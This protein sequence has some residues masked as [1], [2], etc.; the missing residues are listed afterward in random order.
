MILKFP[1]QC[2]SIFNNQK[3]EGVVLPTQFYRKNRMFST[4]GHFIDLYLIMDY[5]ISQDFYINNFEQ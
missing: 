2:I 3:E 1:E 5:L 4:A